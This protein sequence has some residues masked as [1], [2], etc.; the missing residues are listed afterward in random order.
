MGGR[1]ASSGGRGGLAPRGYRTVGK[2]RGISIIKCSD[3]KGKI[4][5]SNAKPNS[6]YFGMNKRGAVKQLR[7]YDGKGNVRKD[8]DWQ[9]SF[10]GHREGTVH[11]HQWNGKVRSL[12]HS[13]LTEAEILKYKKAIENATGRKDLI[14][15][16]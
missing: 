1:G 9:H 4:L 13:P 15:V 7:L 14:W 11:G 12:E 10:D 5:P 16:W 8:I 2:V 3:P 6:R